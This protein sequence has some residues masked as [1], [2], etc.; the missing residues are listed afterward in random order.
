MN[1]Q[2]WP[3]VID[4]DAFDIPA[5]APVDTDVAVDGEVPGELTM[6]DVE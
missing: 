1:P 6:D 4:D 3:P 2:V 5:A